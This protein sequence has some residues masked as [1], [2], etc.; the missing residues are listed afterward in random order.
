MVVAKKD[1]KEESEQSGVEVV[2]ADAALDRLAER[3]D[4]AVR[5]IRALRKERDELKARL[6]ES[7]ARAAGLESDSTKIEDLLSERESW[8]QERDEIRARIE[9]ILGKLDQLDE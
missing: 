4:G 2:D 8:A 6:Q 3:V 5:V 1:R 9:R 7:E